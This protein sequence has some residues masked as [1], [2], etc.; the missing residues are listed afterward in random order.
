[1]RHEPHSSK[2]GD[3]NSNYYP[4]RDFQSQKQRQNHANKERSLEHVLNH[5]V[6]APLK[7]VRAINPYFDRDPVGH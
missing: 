5:H 2:K 4:H 6:Q 3:W 1:M 7:V